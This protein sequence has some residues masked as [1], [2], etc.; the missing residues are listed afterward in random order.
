MSLK[1]PAL[2]SIL[3]AMAAI[4]T[5]EEVGR[6]LIRR[7]GLE[8]VIGNLLLFTFSTSILVGHR[9][10]VRFIGILLPHQRPVYDVFPTLWKQLL[11]GIRR[12][13]MRQHF[14]FPQSPQQSRV[15]NIVGRMKIPEHLPRPT[16]I[17]LL[18]ARRPP[19]T[20][21]MMILTILYGFIKY[22]NFQVLGLYL[23][24]SHGLLE[25]FP[26]KQPQRVLLG[27]RCCHNVAP[28]R[29]ALYPSNRAICLGHFFHREGLRNR[30]YGLLVSS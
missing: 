25:L 19:M 6:R 11:P 16:Q 8:F 18:E 30:A 14:F 28:C 23:L 15:F 27:R 24:Q 22:P 4:M 1:D 29:V 26:I 9:H 17:G 21:N 13:F 2:A 5:S 10:Q 3:P 7:P 12:H 20:R